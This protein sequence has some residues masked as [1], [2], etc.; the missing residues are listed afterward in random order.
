MCIVVLFAAGNEGPAENTHNPYAKAPWVISVAAGVKDGTLADF[1]SRGTKG[2]GGT[3]SMDGKEWTWE[4]RPTITAPGVDIISTRVLAPLSA[5]AAG[6]DVDLIEPQHIPYYTTMSGTSMATP[7]CAGI[8][9][10]LLEH[11]PDLTPDEVKT[12]LKENTSKWSGDDPMIY[13][14]GAIDAEKAIKE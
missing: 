12:L 4:D 2:A 6:K 14:A 1:S 5:L 13:G 9:A 11:S 3:F 10:L 8:C 7:I